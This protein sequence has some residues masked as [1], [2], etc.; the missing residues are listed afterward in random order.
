MTFEDRGC[1]KLP[2]MFLQWFYVI[3]VAFYLYLESQGK[4]AK[5]TVKILVSQ[6]LVCQLSA[7]LGS[8]I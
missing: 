4:N 6:V 5:A 2:Y 7:A 1:Q 8:L 3:Y